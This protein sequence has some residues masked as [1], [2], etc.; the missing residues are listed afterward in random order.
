MFNNKTY[1]AWNNGSA[2]K[3]YHDDYAALTKFDNIEANFGDD[4]WIACESREDCAKFA[5]LKGL[6]R[7]R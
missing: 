6:G 5:K 4:G 3:T 2:V 7:R 1:R